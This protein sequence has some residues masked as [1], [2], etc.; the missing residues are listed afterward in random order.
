MQPASY[1]H[2]G[3]TRGPVLLCHKLR[4]SAEGLRVACCEPVHPSSQKQA[5]RLTGVEQ[6]APVPA[7]VMACRYFLSCTSPAAKTP[8][9]LVRVLPA[10]VST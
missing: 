6:G 5:R 2:T 7:A 3:Q 8:S 10:A 1:P 9:T 4:G